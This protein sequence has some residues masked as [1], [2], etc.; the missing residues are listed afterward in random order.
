MAYANTEIDFSELEEAIVRDIKAA[1][2]GLATVE[3]YREDRTELPLPAVLL[4]MVEWE[5]DEDRDPGTEQLPIIANFE[6]EIIVSFRRV[7]GRKAKAEVRRLANALAAWMH[8]RRWT[9]PDGRLNDSGKPKTMPTGP[10]MVSGAYPDDFQ[11]LENG[12]KGE[13]LDKYEVWRLP[14]QQ[15]VH[16]GKTVWTNDGETPGEPL[17]SF[18]PETGIPNRDEYEEAVDGLI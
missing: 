14:W 6:A 8:N 16:L 12:R 2:P 15:S 17:Y 1:F 18:A 11:G 5:R 10:V 7:E 13:K 9:Y 4:E 3:F